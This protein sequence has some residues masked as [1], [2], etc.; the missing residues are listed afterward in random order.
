MKRLHLFSAVLAMVLVLTLVVS[1]CSGTTSSS[2]SASQ[3]ESSK[4]ASSAAPSSEAPKEKIKISWNIAGDQT[5]YKDDNIVEQAIEAQFPEVDITTLKINSFDNEKLNAT[6]ASGT[7]PDVL[8]KWDVGRFFSEGVIRGITTD[9]MEANMPNT[10]EAMRKAQGD[11]IYTKFID[12]ESGALMAVPQF[13]IGG[14]TGLGEIIR[15]D[16]LDNLGLKAPT[17]LDE[18]YE[19]LKAFTFNDPDGNGK[20][21]TYGIGCPGLHPNVMGASFYYTFGAFGIEPTIWVEDN[22]ELVF[23]NFTEGY[24]NALKELAKWYKEG[25]IDPEFPTTQN[26]D[27]TAKFTNGLFGI[28]FA[29]PSYLDPNTPT[30]WVQTTKANNPKAELKF[31]DP[32]KGP[33]GKSGAPTYGSLGDWGMMFGIKTTDEQV[34]LA[35]RI[36]DWLNSDVDAFTLAFYGKEGEHYDRVDGSIVPRTGFLEVESGIK[37]FRTSSYINWDIMSVFTN[38]A[39]MELTK[40]NMKYPL[41]RKAVDPNQVKAI[42]GD[43]SDNT[44][45]DKIMLEFY[46]NAIT[47]KIDIDKEWDA[48]VASYDKVGGTALRE[49][50]KQVPR[51]D[52]K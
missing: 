4:A 39:V 16:W 20:N 7:I 43:K 10:V 12:K 5:P 40:N 34:E 8:V 17:N 23:G 31:F 50:A 44:E 51:L 6:I 52:K 35:M 3:A 41:I 49:A 21:D 29:H 9:M 28:Y 33:E 11:N 25:L 47:G 32:I 24:K 13:S 2:S 38:P 48:Y 30:G 1:G 42:A 15:Q 26:T 19:V 36:G 14:D 22:G 18:Y 45:I 46:F 27:A 37:V